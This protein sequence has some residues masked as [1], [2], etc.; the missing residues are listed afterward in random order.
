MRETPPVTHTPPR[1]TRFLRLADGR[2]ARVAPR[3]AV[4][5]PIGDLVPMIV[6][7]L[8]GGPEFDALLPERWAE[9]RDGEFRRL[10]AASI[11]LQALKHPR[12]T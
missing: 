1:P 8:D 7:P 6:M 5:C 11:E 3:D 12:S 10:V 9:L 4:P 2:Y